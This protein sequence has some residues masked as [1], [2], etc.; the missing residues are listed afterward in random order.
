MICANAVKSI[1]KFGFNG[2][3]VNVNKPILYEALNIIEVTNI[4]FVDALICAKNK[5]QGFEK[6]SFDNDLKEC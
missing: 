1:A 5:L 4:D 2:V 3:V 6:L